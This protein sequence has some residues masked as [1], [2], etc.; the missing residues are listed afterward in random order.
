MV[1]YIH[2]NKND[3]CIVPLTFVK[4]NRQSYQKMTRQYAVQMDH[5]H[6]VLFERSVYFSYLASYSAVFIKM[7]EKEGDEYSILRKTEM[8]FNS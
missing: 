1:I 6:R 7:K 8:N 4:E 3:L 5:S 2:A